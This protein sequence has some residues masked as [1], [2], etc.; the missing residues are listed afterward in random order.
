MNRGR[1]L[2]RAGNHV[3]AAEAFAAAARSA[4]RGQD[5]RE[6]LFQRA[7]S[8]K[9]ANRPDAAADAYR[10]LLGKYPADALGW[11]LYGTFLRKGGRAA[12]AV[13]AFR[14]SLEIRD[15]ISTRNGLVMALCNADRMD[16]AVAEG[17]RSLRQKDAEALARFDGPASLNPPPVGNL[18]FNPKTP[19]KNI[20]AFSLWGDDPV[21]IHGAIVNARIAPHIYYGWTPRF[22]CDPSVPADVVAELRRLGAQV[23]LFEDPAL[24]AIRPMWRFLASDDPSVDWFVCRDTDCRLNCQEFIAVEEWL[25]S[26]RPFHV[27]RDH[28]YHIDL[29]L[30]GMWGG[31]AGMLPNMKEGP[32]VLAPIFQQP[33]RRPAFPDGEGLAA[34]KGPCVHARYL[35]WLPGWQGIP[36]CLPLAPAPS[37]RRRGET[38]AGLEIASRVA[39]PVFV[40]RHAV[41]R[42]WR[43]HPP[44]DPVWSGSSGGPAHNPQSGPSIRRSSYPG[45]AS[46]QPIRP[47]G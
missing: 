2:R 25:K 13:D 38:N 32:A 31:R 20:I 3:E 6:A 11:A 1:Q 43:K 9:D 41:R 24:Q 40:N 45:G 21:Y 28:V 26:G 30:A 19:R 4:G 46:R 42:R 29:I 18:P 44:L 10:A 12:E 17:L 14:R 16:E 47:F 8:L 37:C 39:D 23:V 35:L 7:T 15:D 27:M 22:Y 36:R 34:D 33:L 5:E